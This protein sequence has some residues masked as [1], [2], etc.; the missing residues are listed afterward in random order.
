MASFR[1]AHLAS[2]RLGAPRFGLPALAGDGEHAL[3]DCLRRCREAAVDFVLL[4]GDLFPQRE[5]A[6]GVLAQA[7][8]ALGE[9]EGIPLVTVETRPGSF[10]GYLEQRGLLICLTPTSVPG[11]PTLATPW[12]PGAPP[13]SYHDPLPGVRVH[14][15]AP[16]APER[17][18]QLT[19]LPRGAHANLGLLPAPRSHLED[20][21][22]PTLAKIL[23]YLACGGSEP[24]G[25]D[26]WAWSP[27]PLQEVLTGEVREAPP[28]FYLVDHQDGYEAERREVEGRPVHRLPPLEVRDLEHPEELLPSLGSHLEGHEL[29]PEAVVLLT[30]R[31][32]VPEAFPRIDPRP[33][34]ES[35]RRQL[36]IDHVVLTLRFNSSHLEEAGTLD[37]REV[38]REVLREALQDELPDQQER[39]PELLDLLASIRRRTPE[40]DADLL[41]ILELARDLAGEEP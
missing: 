30:L 39:H 29:P 27:G 5:I 38:E 31:G 24:P 37:R 20:A 23:D 25:Q 2:V 26:G 34:E 17:S 1:F 15:L 41:E 36:G 6:P 28:G 16:G 7:E 35:V 11:G 10:L 19:Q 13:A 21:T 8:R 22:Q 9:L 18:R 4:A 40:S 32:S 33:L 14:A 3:T 12:R